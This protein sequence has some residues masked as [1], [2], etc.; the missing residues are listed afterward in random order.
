MSHVF[1]QQV[2]NIRFSSGDENVVLFAIRCELNCDPIL[3]LTMIKGRKMKVTVSVVLC[4]ST[5]LEVSNVFVDLGIFLCD[6]CT[7]QITE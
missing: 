6:I 5:S 1:L 3:L 2:I 7:K 4:F